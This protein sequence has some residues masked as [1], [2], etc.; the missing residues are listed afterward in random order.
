MPKGANTVV[1]QENV[2]K[3]DNT[4]IVENIPRKFQNIR[5]KGFDFRINSILLKKGTR[6]TPKHIALSAAMNYRKL[7]VIERPSVAIISTGSELVEPGSL[8]AK[9]NIICSSN[10][11]IK[12]YIESL[13]GVATDFGIVPDEINSIKKIQ[14]CKGVGAFF[15]VH[16]DKG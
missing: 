2:K 10:Y 15:Y 4:I 6:L 8:Q 3:K 11:G 13:G 14:I 5:K 16:V 1:I 9:N 12:T 7:P